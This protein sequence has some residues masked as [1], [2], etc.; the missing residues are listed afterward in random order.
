MNKLELK[1]F[2]D[3]NRENYSIQLK[4]L[5]KSI[6][7]DIDNLYDFSSFGQK[8]Y[9]YLNDGELGKCEICG[10]L[11]K[12]DSFYKGYRRRCSYDCMGKCKY[13]KSHETRQCRICGQTFNTYKLREK[14]TCSEKCLLVLN[15]SQDVNEKRTSTLKNTMLE[16]YG[17]DHYSKLPDF[18]IKVKKTKKEKYGNENYVNA[19]KAKQTKLEKY[20][21]KTF[22][23]SEKIKQTKLKKYND[24][25]YNNREKFKKSNVEKY[26]VEYPIKLDK[27]KL[28]SKITS[29]SN[30]GS[31]YPTQSEEVKNK[32]KQTNLERYGVDSVMKNS[33]IK[34]KSLSNLRKTSFN[35]VINSPKLLQF[36][37]PLFNE[38]EYV[39]TFR[40]NL[41]KFQCK[42][43]NDV[44]EDN[45][46]GG[47]IPRCWKCYPYV[48]S[49]IESDIIDYIKTLLPSFEILRNNRGVLSDNKELDIYIPDKKIA[50]EYDGLYWHSEASGGKDKNYH[51]NKTVECKNKGIRLIHVFEDEWLNKQDIVKNRLRHIFG[52]NNNDKIYARNCIIKEIATKLKSEFLENYHIQGNDKSLI[53]LGAFYN[54]ELV[55]V[56]TFGKVRIIMGN[57]NK[58]AWE[59]LRFCVGSK[60]VVGIAGKLFAY[61]TKKYKPNKILSYADRRYS[62]DSA[63]YEKIG[64]KFVDYTAPNYWYI[65]NNEIKRHYRFNFRKSVLSKIL[66]HVDMNLT[67]WQN[68]QLNGYDR[69]WDCGHLKFVW[70]NPCTF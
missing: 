10:K 64:F 26:G 40:S 16:K 61:F 42:K 38:S 46:D 53:R 52:V 39:N 65:K 24:E 67:E 37:I 7:D 23:N 51:L 22:N 30:F 25:N 66:Q 20:G 68:M 9:H 43:C 57:K 1:K 59:L 49:R 29:L 28:K 19:E 69:I 60:F 54:N 12:F 36:V 31:E 2:I 63:F 45:I 50:I 32:I 27:F 58:D 17:V 47:R 44:F 48:R 35:T 56:M 15:S 3:N 70:S 62:D 55:A 18:N 5:H 21:N 4:R 34:N 14:T 13:A 33:E 8:L 11:C 6:F 41:Y